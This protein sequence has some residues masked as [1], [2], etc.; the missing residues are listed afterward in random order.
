M[1]YVT[2]LGQAAGKWQCGKSTSSES[3]FRFCALSVIHTTF[4]IYNIFESYYP[5][6]DFGQT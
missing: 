2:Y 1:A 5:A 6:N 4:V 3:N